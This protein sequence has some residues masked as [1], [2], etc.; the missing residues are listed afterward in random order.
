MPLEI[1][2]KLASHTADEAKR[3][4][5][6]TSYELSDVTATPLK[7]VGTGYF[8]LM[9]QQATLTHKHTMAHLMG[10]L[11]L[12]PVRMQLQTP[13]PLV[14][15]S[16]LSAHNKQQPAEL[17]VTHSLDTLLTAGKPR[18]DSQ[19]SSANRTIPWHNDRRHTL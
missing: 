14:L 19:G 10:G 4:A 16:S 3:Y 2:A 17:L 13:L 18:V 9:P 11:S 8:F 12:I 15:L 5:A 7:L 1:S 6:N